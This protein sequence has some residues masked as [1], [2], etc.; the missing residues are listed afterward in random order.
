MA[1]Y[2]R[3]G[4]LHSQH[5]YSIGT[6]LIPLLHTNT[7]CMLCDWEVAVTVTTRTEPGQAEDWFVRT[8]IASAE[9]AGG[10]GQI[11]PVL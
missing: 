3:R 7:H 9:G 10:E 8:S 4:P 6:D 11:E 5:L 1:A 2:R